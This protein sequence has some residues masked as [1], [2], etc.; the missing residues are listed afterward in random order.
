MILTGHRPARVSGQPSISS[1]KRKNWRTIMQPKAPR[2]GY[3]RCETLLP[4]LGCFILQHRKTP[5]RHAMCLHTEDGRLV[6][7][8]TAE[9]AEGIADLLAQA[10]SD[11]RKAS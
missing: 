11:M 9:S 6:I 4:T 7:G 3:V 5:T 1:A 10:A 2:D 8:L